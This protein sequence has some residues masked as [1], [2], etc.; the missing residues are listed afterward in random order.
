[1]VN[2]I[3]APE[4]EEIKEAIEIRSRGKF[5]KRIEF[6]STGCSMLNLAVSGRIENG[7]WPRARVINLVGDGSSGKTILALEACAAAYWSWR[8]GTDFGKGHSQIF[9]P[10][11]KLIIIYNNVEG[12]MDFDVE[13]M[14]GE[15][16]YNHVIWISSATIEAFGS[17]IFNRIIDIKKGDT[18]IYVADSWDAM[19]SEEDQKKFDKKIA[20]DRKR[21]DDSGNL[22]AQSAA[23]AKKE[24]GS[25]ELGKQAYA[26]K[27]FFKKLTAE[28]QNKD[29]DLT[30]FI[31]SQVRTKIGVTFGKKK[32]RAGGDALNFY[33]H[34][35]VWLREIEKL[36]MQ[37][38]GQERVYGVDAEAKVER[39]K[40]WKPFRMC[41]FRVIFDYGVDDIYS[42]M[43]YY[44]GPKKAECEWLGDKYKRADLYELFRTDKEHLSLFKQAVQAI[45]DDVEE[46]VAP[47][48]RKYEKYYK[49]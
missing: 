4:P 46:A 32:Y 37:R 3:K 13:A 38:L 12:V 5:S 7:G 1:M 30:L 43:R 10:T 31:I 18:V 44:F 21:L 39:S 22:A 49:E 25:Y 26:S 23:A 42:M 8:M 19:D 29:A 35:V 24:T 15:D 34:T 40:V 41:Q 9:N 11:K 36:K 27:R 28:V 2:R 6:L 16:F 33:T 17:D 14:Y 47:K 48:H 45:W 20:T